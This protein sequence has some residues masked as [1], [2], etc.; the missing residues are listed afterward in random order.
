MPKQNNRVLLQ[1]LV[2]YRWPG[3][4]Y[5]TDMLRC[6]LWIGAPSRLVRWGRVAEKDHVRGLAM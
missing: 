3:A 2:P 4:L 5:G 1:S 6:A